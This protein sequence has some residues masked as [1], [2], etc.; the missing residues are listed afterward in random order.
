MREAIEPLI[1]RKSKPCGGCLRG[2]TP[3]Q[4]HGGL[5]LSV[6]PVYDR[7]HEARRKLGVSSSREAARMLAQAELSDLGLSADKQL[8]VAPGTGD[9]DTDG[10]RRR[11]PGMARWPGGGILVV[12][13]V[14]AAI[15]L[16]SW[17]WSAD[18]VPSLSEPAT[19]TAS[20]AG[21][22]TAQAEGSVI[23]YIRY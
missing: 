23:A 2:M 8:G 6:H 10:Q 12:M 17:L 15:A 20:D 7:L 16:V 14:T 13:F 5:G 3:N 22:P 11:T 9:S 1:E 21:A 19:A 18:P 4:A